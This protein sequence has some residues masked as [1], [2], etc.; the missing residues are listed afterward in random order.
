MRL[1][2]CSL[3]AKDVSLRLILDLLRSKKETERLHDLQKAQNPLP[4]PKARPRA[5]SPVDTISEIDSEASPRASTSQLPDLDDEELDELV[6]SSDDEDD[7]EDLDDLDLD[8]PLPHQVATKKKKKTNSDD[9]EA[10]YENAEKRRRYVGS[11]SE[12]DD[13]S[14]GSKVNRLPIKL[15]TGEIQ[16][17]AGTSIV[18]PQLKRPAKPVVES[19]DEQEEPEEEDLPEGHGLGKR[20]GRMAVADVVSI[21]NPME[22]KRAVKEQIAS[23]GAEIVGGG[24]IVDNVSSSPLCSFSSVKGNSAGSRLTLDPSTSL[25]AA[26][27]L[28]PRLLWSSD[29]PQPESRGE[30]YPESD[31]RPSNGHRL[32]AG[33]VQGPDSWLPVG[34]RPPPSQ[35]LSM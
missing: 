15:P 4:K 25:P 20:W 5:P 19:E 14:K 30:A 18:P 32:A 27:Y 1:L 3:L 8:I 29:G 10:S 35:T 13:P 22:R 2:T 16:K 9:E 21:K 33:R 12:D 6:F 17:V 31:E 23:L 11:D 34:R 24:E 26:P 28:S 7:L